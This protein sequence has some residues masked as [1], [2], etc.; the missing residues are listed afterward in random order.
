MKTIVFTPSFIFPA[1]RLYR[2]SARPDPGQKGQTQL[3]QKSQNQITCLL[4]KKKGGVKTI[5]MMSWWRE[6]DRKVVVVVVV[7]MRVERKQ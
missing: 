5:E 3:G 4:E 6:N 2:R 7:K 1:D